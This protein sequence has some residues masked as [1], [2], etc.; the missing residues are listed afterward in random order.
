ME[1]PVPFDPLV[2]GVRNNQVVPNPIRENEV[3]PNPIRENEVVPN[4][5]RRVSNIVGLAPAL[6]HKG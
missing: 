3:V 6:V 4:P 2:L 5:I 1:N